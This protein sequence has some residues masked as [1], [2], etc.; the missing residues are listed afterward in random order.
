VQ[1]W[2]TRHRRSDDQLDAFYD[3]ALAVTETGPPEASS[4]TSEEDQHVAWVPAA[5]VF[6]TFLAIDQDKTVFVQRI[7]PA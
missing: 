3:W 1:E 6:V 7:D 5:R 2:A 4:P